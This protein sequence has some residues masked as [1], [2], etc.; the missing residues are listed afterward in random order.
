MPRPQLRF[1]LPKTAIQLSARAINLKSNNQTYQYDSKLDTDPGYY[2]DIIFT[3]LVLVDDQRNA[4][5]TLNAYGQQRKKGIYVY[6]PD[7]DIF[8]DLELKKPELVLKLNL[9]KMH[10]AGEWCECATTVEFKVTQIER[11][12][13]IRIRH[14]ELFC[15]SAS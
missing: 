3:G 9:N 6:L 12:N 10:K 7:L 8:D 5:E 13:G 2:N 15:E 4:D 1:R 14:I 11:P